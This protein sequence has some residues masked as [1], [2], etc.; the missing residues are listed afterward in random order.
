MHRALYT[1]SKNGLFEL[2][3]FHHHAGEF[4]MQAWCKAWSVQTVPCCFPSKYL[5]TDLAHRN[6]NSRTEGMAR[7]SYSETKKEPSQTEEDSKSDL[8][9]EEDEA[10]IFGTLSPTTFPKQSD[11][12][13][14]SLDL[15]ID[16]E[17]RDWKRE[18]RRR[19]TPY[20]YAMQMKKLVKKG[21]L[22]EAIDMLETRMLKED[23]VKPIEYNYDVLIGACGRAGYTKKAF[24]LYNRMKERNLSPSD[25]TYTSLFNACAESPWPLEDGYPRLKKLHQ[26]LLDKQIKVNLITHHAM[27]KAYG[28][29][30]DIEG[31]FH[32]FHHLLS[33]G[34][35]ITRSFGSILIACASNKQSGFTYAIEAWRQMIARGLQPDHYCFN[36]LLRVVRDCDI[37][38]P[39]IASKILLKPVKVADS[40]LISAGRNKRG[41]GRKKRDEKS[42]MTNETENKKFEEMIKLEPASV[43]DVN[44]EAIKTDSDLAQM[45]RDLDVEWS[46]KG[47]SVD[48]A[49]KSINVRKPEKWWE[50][51]TGGDFVKST[52]ISLFNSSQS[53]QVIPSGVPNLLDEKADFS[54]VESLATIQTT[55]DRLMLLG[56]CEGIL[57]QMK[58]Y[59]VKPD[60]KT[61]S[62]LSELVPMTTEEEEKLMDCADKV[63]V[64]LDVDFYNM[65]IHRRS[66][67]GKLEEA[68]EIVST[69]HQKGLQPNVRTF[70][71]LAI[72]CM[73]M[74][75]GIQVLSDMKDLDIKPNVVVYGALMNAAFKARDFHYLTIL[76]NHMKASGVKPNERII[77][78]L[79]VAS[80]FGSRAPAD[81]KPKASVMKRVNQFRG[82]YYRWLS[83]ME[84]EETPHPWDQFEISKTQTKE[85]TSE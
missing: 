11:T 20:W 5:H 82:F 72:H 37:G 43:I 1:S 81:K 53:L 55:S 22:S 6:N 38:D 41:K 61:F 71:N 35:V 12:A 73:T 32:L 83:E 64:L 48:E 27:I 79:E 62:L 69:I 25:V 30:G 39:Q 58:N 70:A 31:A 56:G 65:L 9:E 77:E 3:K 52:D 66:K 78:L 14:S 49:K 19:N 45:E 51:S 34:C 18:R 80:S 75:D 2:K 29:C 8:L 13:I 16:E 57:T 10:D 59:N 84:A 4:C 54:N 33:S 68:K 74:K 36:L 24:K 15:E 50:S 7:E 40:N 46:L 42:V 44:G 21:K 23:Y 28:K 47:S 17:E 85:E 76:L 26:Y 63:N 60:I 67:R